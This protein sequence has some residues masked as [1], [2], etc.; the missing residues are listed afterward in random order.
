MQQAVLCSESQAWQF[1][2]S[3]LRLISLTCVLCEINDVS[4]VA[5]VVTPASPSFLG[6]RTQTALVPATSAVTPRLYEPSWRERL[7]SA[8]GLEQLRA[9]SQKDHLGSSLTLMEVERR[10]TALR[11]RTALLALPQL[12]HWICRLRLASHLTGMMKERL[13]L[14]KMTPWRGKRSFLI[15]LRNRWTCGR[16]WN[17]TNLKTRSEMILRK[18]TLQSACLIFPYICSP[19]VGSREAGPVGWYCVPH[20]H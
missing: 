20:V 1:K 10:A 13:A 8:P 18:T 15:F 7:P 17:T 16:W 2:H 9:Q 6:T 14:V 4:Y 3:F 12:F 5:V 19:A 11:G